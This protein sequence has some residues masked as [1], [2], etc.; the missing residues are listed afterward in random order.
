MEELMTRIADAL[1]K[2]EA[3]QIDNQKQI[4]QYQNLKHDIDATVIEAIKARQPVKNTLDPQLFAKHVA[5]ALISRLP[6]ATELRNATEQLTQQVKNEGQAI[7]ANLTALT[8]KIPTS[9][10]I[11]GHFY[12]FTSWK[13]FGAYTA[14]LLLAGVLC[15]WSWYEKQ[16]MVQYKQAM[17]LLQERNHFVKQIEK[18]VDENPTYGSKYFPDYNDQGFWDKFNNELT[19]PQAGK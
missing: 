13:P 1:E 11:T 17:Q 6:D 15:G 7:T 4:Q 8:N 2:V 12:G 10:P 5:P 3:I 18:Y 16:E 19:A 9:I 14:I